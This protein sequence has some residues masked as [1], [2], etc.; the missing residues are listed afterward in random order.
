M[1][2]NIIGT[3]S[4]IGMK[5]FYYKIEQFSVLTHHQYVAMF[6]HIF[7]SAAK[8]ILALDIVRPFAINFAFRCCCY[9]RLKSMILSNA[10]RFERLHVWACVSRQTQNKTEK[11]HVAQSIQSHTFYK[12]KKQS[13]FVVMCI[14]CVWKRRCVRCKVNA[15]KRAI[16]KS[17][18]KK[19]QRKRYVW[20]KQQR[21]RRLLFI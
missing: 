16:G 6:T 11:F 1:C 20:L 9:A 15:T 4:C 8:F 3:Q 21:Q 17:E 10:F 7:R 12:S 19:K 18:R 5:Q 14:N 13:T 2:M